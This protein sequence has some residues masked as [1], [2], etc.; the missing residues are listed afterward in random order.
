MR[1]EDPGKIR[2]A[3]DIS[4][5]SGGPLDLRAGAVGSLSCVLSPSGNSPEP[6]IQEMAMG[7]GGTWAMHGLRSSAGDSKVQA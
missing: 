2:R 4:R 7:S 6:A 1:N 5:G 3:L